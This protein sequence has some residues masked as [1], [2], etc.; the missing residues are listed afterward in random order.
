MDIFNQNIKEHRLIKGYSQDDIAKYLNVSRTVYTQIENGKRKVTSDEVIALAKLYGVTTD[1]LLLDVPVGTEK[2]LDDKDPFTNAVSGFF[3]VNISR[4]EIIGNV[5]IINDIG[6]HLWIDPSKKDTG[7]LSYDGFEQWWKKNMHVD[8]RQSFFSLYSSRGLI[9]SYEKGNKVAEY[10]YVSEKNET[11]R[12][13][14]KYTCYMSQ[15]RNRDIYGFISF[16]DFSNVSLTKEDGRQFSEL[17]DALSE[18]F[19]CLYYVDIRDDSYIL[20][21]NHG[22]FSKLNDHVSEKNFFVEF[23]KKIRLFICKED[24]KTISSFMTKE[25]LLAEFRNGAKSVMS[26]FFRLIVDGKSVYYTIRASVRSSDANHMLI[27]LENVT[28]CLTREFSYKEQL[29]RDKEIIEVLSEEFSSV[30]CVNLSENSFAAC[31]IDEVTVSVYGND[32]FKNTSYTGI[33]KACVEKMVYEPDR[34]KMYEEGSIYNILLKLKD[35]NSFSTVYRS[36]INGKIQYCEMKIVKIGN[37]EFP[38]KVVIGFADRS[39][40]KNKEIERDIYIQK[41]LNLSQNLEGICE[42]NLE[43]GFYHFRQAVDFA[44]EETKVPY[45]RE[46]YIYEDAIKEFILA[47]V[48]EEDRGKIQTLLSMEGLNGLLKKRPCFEEKFRSTYGNTF[49]WKCMKGVLN[50]QN[51]A[52]S[53]IIGIYNIDKEH[54]LEQK[55]AAKIVKLS[56]EAYIDKLCGIKNR[57]AYIIK[58]SEI[59]SAMQAGKAEDF[60]VAVFDINNLKQI[61]DNQGHLE[62]DELITASSK[63]ICDTFKHSP[64]YRIGGDEFVVF[65]TGSDFSERKSLFDT[66]YKK[67]KELGKG[68]PVFSGGMAEKR[69]KDRNVSDIFKR[70]DEAMYDNKKRNRE[71]TV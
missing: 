25:K 30:Y 20:I 18:S 60:A 54:R 22:L 67:A 55:K 69:K 52:K 59:N 17:T 42:I 46:G 9:T 44:V 48:Y 29:K 31:K 24:Y 45:F 70:A 7:R 37:E 19:E 56:Y 26:D 39:S 50:S 51:D 32:F 65:M 36:L 23:I 8:D 41:I 34:E 12:R 66:I 13:S 40:E 57:N 14:I 35:R 21:N 64:V 43:T 62:G 1:S 49:I 71:L 68:T 28:D 15:L 38:T 16:Y 6:E 2:T 27:V 5:S 63:L 10:T 33:Y 61:N 58:E 4:N 47:E 3:E 53:V 11:Q